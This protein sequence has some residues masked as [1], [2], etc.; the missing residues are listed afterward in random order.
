MKL[1]VPLILAS[2]SPRRRKLLAQLGLDFEVHPSDLDENAT[3]H[4]LPEQLV[5]QL[6]LEKART[7]AARFP[8]ALT[9]GADTIVVLDGDVLNKPADEAEARAMLRRLS[10]RTHTVY[11]GVALVHPASQREIVDYEATEV[12]FAPLTDAEI[13]AYVAT[14]SPLDKAGAYGIQD[15]YGAVFIRRIEGDYY[16]VVGLPLHRLYRMLRNHFA[17]LIED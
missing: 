15:D 12:T 3:N 14:G 16:N 7:V 6:A 13:D 17:D 4:R 5:E 2:R 11:T 1:R 10:G 9:L 8:E